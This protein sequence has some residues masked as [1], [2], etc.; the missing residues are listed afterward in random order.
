MRYRT[1]TYRP[2]SAEDINEYRQL[3]AFK[4]SIIIEKVLYYLCK[5]PGQL[6]ALCNKYSLSQ[7]T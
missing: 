3:V 7:L 1:D 2:T 6:T 4:F 5:Y